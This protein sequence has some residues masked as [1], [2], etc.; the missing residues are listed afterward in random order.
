[1][2][3]QQITIIQITS[4]CMNISS[5]SYHIDDLNTFIMSFKIKPKVI[6]IRISKCRLKAAGRPPLSNININKLI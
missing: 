2:N 3:L 5:V 6:D 4:L 1:M